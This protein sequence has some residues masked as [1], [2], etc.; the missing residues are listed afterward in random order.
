MI[1]GQLRAAREN[2]RWMQDTIIAIC[3]HCLEHGMR[4]AA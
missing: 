1:P 3:N 2:V 4:P